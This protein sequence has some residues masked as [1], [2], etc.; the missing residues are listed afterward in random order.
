MLRVGLLGQGDWAPQLHQAASPAAFIALMCAAGH[1]EQCTISIL[2]A[3]RF[4]AVHPFRE[5]IATV[6]I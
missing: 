6:I 4:R 1:A 5:L 3:G 2:T